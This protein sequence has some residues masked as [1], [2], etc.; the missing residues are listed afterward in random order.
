[1]KK[2]LIFCSGLLLAAGFFCKVVIASPAVLY[3]ATL[4]DDIINP[5]TQEYLESAIDQAE[6]D[7]AEALVIVLDTPGGLLTST[8]AIVK[9][10]MNAEVLMHLKAMPG[11]TRT[12]TSAVS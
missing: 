11:V 10:M 8:R 9:R 3:V 5:V 7:G 12:N 1:M 6:A 2:S 4:D